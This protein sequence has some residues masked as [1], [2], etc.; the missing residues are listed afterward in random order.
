VDHLLAVAAD[1][2]YRRVS[3]ETGTMDRFTA[4]R[5]LYAKA[6]FVPCPPFANYTDNPHSTCMTIGLP[7]RAPVVLE[8]RLE[9]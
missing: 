1:R 9:E 6:G 5:S 7:E 4:A 3:L 2:G 8:E